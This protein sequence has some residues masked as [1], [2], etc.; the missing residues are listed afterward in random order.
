MPTSVHDVVS[1]FAFDAMQVFGYLVFAAAITV[2]VLAIMRATIELGEAY[3]KFRATRKQLAF[4]FQPPSAKVLTFEAPRKT[5]N[6]VV[7][8]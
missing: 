8:R 1:P 4:K 6:R 3:E 7:V 5:R 2:L